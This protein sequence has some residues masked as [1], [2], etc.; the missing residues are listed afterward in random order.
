[1]HAQQRK[2]ILTHNVTARVSDTEYRALQDRADAE[3]KTLSE[4]ARQELVG[5]TGIPPK[6]RRMLEFLMIGEEKIRLRLEAAQSGIDICLP[7]I[8][9]RIENE[10]TL[11]APILVERRLRL[12]CGQ[13]SEAEA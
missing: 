9:E 10:A 2:R 13:V 11:A 3:K 12:L 1:M 8:R 5:S 4:Y 7:E 6:E